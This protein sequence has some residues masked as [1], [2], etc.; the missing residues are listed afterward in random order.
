MQRVRLIL[1]CLLSITGG[2]SVRAADWLN[3][4][5]LFDDV[6]LTLANGHRI[7]AA[8]PLFYSE[9]K[10]LQTTWAIPPLVA[11]LQ[12]AGT[13]SEEWDF[14]YPIAS[15]DRFGTEYRWHIGQLF[16]FAGGE[17]Q[18]QQKARRFTLFPLYFQQRSPNPEENYTALIPVYGHLKK[19]LLR[20]EIFF[21]MFPIYSETRKKDVVTDNY[22]YPIFHLRRGD[23]LMG[24]QFWPIVGHEHKDITQKTNGFGDVQLVPG[25]DS[26][27]ILWPI[28]FNQTSEIGMTNQQHQQAVL[29][30]FSLQRSP[31]RDSTTVGW[32]FFSHITDREKK[33][34]EW[35]LP[36]PLIVFARGEGK[37]TSR[38]WPFFSEAQSTNL[39][40]RFYLWPVYKYNRVHGDLVDRE[41]TRILFF[42]YSDILQKNLETGKAQH[43]VDFFPFY[44]FRRDYDGSSRLQV[45]SILEPFLPQSKSIERDYS[46]LW[47]LWRSEHNSKTSA[48]SQSLLW[49]L[50]RRD[51]TPESRKCSLLFGLFQYQS[52]SDGKRF[53]LFYIPVVKPKPTDPIYKTVG[54]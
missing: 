33:Y 39:E 45:L 44:T 48:C 20:D 24:W 9:E 8:G 37:T 49:N 30:L 35:Q 38:V 19:R 23:G 11:H 29:P 27:F 17:N 2:I 6:P 52:G 4:G 28:Y 1:V 47:S 12:D 5:P 15:L 3:A 53:R 50:Y 22:V 40:S 25:R 26:R 54:S 42:L 10:D 46:P 43:R 16:S 13:D 51:V 41:R 21:V 36:W 31:L 18:E 7:E 14:L 34:T 32:P